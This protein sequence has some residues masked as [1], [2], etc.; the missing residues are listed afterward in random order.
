MKRLFTL[1]I[2]GFFLQSVNAQVDSLII[3]PSTGE[4]SII[5]VKEVSIPESDSTN[6]QTSIPVVEKTTIETNEIDTIRIDVENDKVNLVVGEGV[7]VKVEKNDSTGN[8]ITYIK[9][10]NGEL[11][12]PDTTVIE[13]AGYSI[14]FNNDYAEVKRRKKRNSPSSWRKLT[15]WAGLDIGVNGYVTPDF[16]FNIDDEAKFMALNWG[17]SRTFSINPVEWK[18]KIYQNFIGITTGLGLEWNSY[19]L[20]NL[21]YAMAFNA[22][23]T[24]GVKP[25]NPGVNK[26]KFRTTYINAP[27]LLEFNTSRYRKNNFHIAAGVVIGWKI[28]TMYKQ[29]YRDE[30]KHKD[31]TYGNWNVQSFRFNAMVRLGYG[32]LNLFATYGLNPLFRDGAGP[33]LHQFSAGITIIGW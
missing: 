11:H 14:E 31:K 21:D 12:I 26:S 5:H 18:I 25:T 9:I 1:I 24:F 29:R 8:K 22:D 20:R 6:L 7:I 28:R 2:V 10:E 15:Y 19:R 13:I 33:K 23:S 27:F 3:E 16:N 32:G 4:Q 17:N 30:G